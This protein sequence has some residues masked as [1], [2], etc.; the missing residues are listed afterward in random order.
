M[1]LIEMDSYPLLQDDSSVCSSDEMLLYKRPIRKVK[2]S[3][4]QYKELSDDEKG[5]KVAIPRHLGLAGCIWYIIGQVIGTGIFISPSGVLRGTG[6][7][8][9]W[10]LLLW[11]LC[12]I[13]Q[14]CGALVYAEL[15][16]IM[17]KSGGDFTFLLQAW[18][19][20][21]SFSRLWVTTLVNP[22]SI[23]IQALVIAKYLLTPFF[24]CM[25]EPL[26]AVRFISICCILFIVYVN[27][28]SIKFSARLTGFLTF[29]KMFGLI[30]IFVSGIYN[31][32]QGHT[33]YLESAFSSGH[34]DV[35]LL[36]VGFFSGLYALSGWEIITTITEEIDR[37][38]RNIP[39]SLFISMATIT[40]VYLM[41]NVAYFTLLS[42]SQMLA[43]GAVAADYS[44][45][46]LGNWSWL[47]WIFVAMSALGSANASV[48]ARSRT[49]FVAARE[50]LF[51][52]ILSMISLKHSTPLPS[53]VILLIALMYVVEDDVIVL[54]EYTMFVDLLFILL[55]CCI[56]PYYRWKYPDIHRPFKI[57]LFVVGIYISSVLFLLG[58]ALYSDPVGKLIGLGFA[59][60]GL[61]VYF[62]F[63]HPK[64][65]LK[66]TA[67][68][69]GKITRF[70]QRVFFCVRQEK[71][72][73]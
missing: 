73:F 17:R 37:P 15:S 52:E 18:G 36:P 68:I 19:P 4:T 47:I 65:K 27:C 20:M 60:T 33:K 48:I 8:V 58:I 63:L 62:A 66:C 23:A 11:I 32:Q 25:E 55:T 69:S 26:L 71:E 57:P 54:I 46:A 39:L 44:V 70:L 24:Q 2:D 43:S 38:V 7:S 35:S 13:I 3:T 67:A 31:L 1:D 51:P 10:A 5:E 6:G 28:V 64:Y 30:A 72:T 9:G 29:T 49:V 53:I 56:L 12:A 16:L 45:L 59:L 34:L 50:G 21:V 41:A 42:P 40:A 61:P 14:F 22:C